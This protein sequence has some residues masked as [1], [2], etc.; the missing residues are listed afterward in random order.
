[1]AIYGVRV[2]VIPVFMIYPQS[3]CLGR[4]TPESKTCKHMVLWRSSKCMN[5]KTTVCI[6]R[7]VIPHKKGIYLDIMLVSANLVQV[8]DPFHQD[9]LIKPMS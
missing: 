7:S 8:S 6:H 5:A 3:P 9:D 1:M 2:Y 4:L